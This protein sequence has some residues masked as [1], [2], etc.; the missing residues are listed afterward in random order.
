[1]TSVPRSVEDGHSRIRCTRFKSRY[2]LLT[3]DDRGGVKNIITGFNYIPVLIKKIII[4]K[5]IYSASASTMLMLMFFVV[6][7]LSL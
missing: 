6:V 4:K 7:E 1:M 5:N 3:Y 2:I